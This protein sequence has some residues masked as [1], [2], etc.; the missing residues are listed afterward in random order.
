MRGQLAFSSI[1][2]LGIALV[3]CG[4]GSDGQDDQK[5]VTQAP[6]TTVTTQ[7]VGSNST[8]VSQASTATA[9]TPA[10]PATASPTTADAT[11]TAVPAS[12][13]AAQPM[14]TPSAATS[15]PPPPPPPPP[16]PTA[17]PPPASSN[18]LTASV[19][20]SGTARYFWSPSKVTVAPG[21]AVTFAWSGGAAHDLSV[22]QLGFSS[23]ATTSASHTVTFPAAGSYSVVCVIHGDTMKGTV[24]VQ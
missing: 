12:A 19:G 21:G 7:P 5:T 20:V 8:Q 2:A 13:T 15:T 11:A 24:V 18:P 16:P 1:L 17:T 23:A 6:P 4:G 10:E 3:A 14:S 22:P 9:T